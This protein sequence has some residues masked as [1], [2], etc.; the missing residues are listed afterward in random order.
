MKRFKVFIKL[1]AITILLGIILIFAFGYGNYVKVSNKIS[2][3]EKVGIIQQTQS[4]TRIENISPYLIQ[5][6][7]SIEDHRF[8]EHH[9]IDFVSLLRAFINNL[10]SKGIVGGGSTI[11]QQLAK[12]MFYSY[13]ASYIRKISEMFSAIDLE[14]KLDKNEILELYVNIINYGDNHMGIYEASM[15]YFDKVP[16]DL[17][18]A[19]ASLLAGIPQSPANFQLSNHLEDAKI[20]QK[21]VLEA[22][23]RDGWITQSEMETVLRES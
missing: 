16:S 17:T 19:E 7:I 9:G 4:Y 12:N 21:A 11:T 15:G 14:K 10:F 20:R 5:A 3:E 18:L 23:V 8:Y 13:N 1:I 2:V 22:M 6:T